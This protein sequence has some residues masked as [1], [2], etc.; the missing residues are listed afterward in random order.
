[1]L[2]YYNP[3]TQEWS[4]FP[5]PGFVIADPDYLFGNQSSKP[6]SL[7]S[8]SKSAIL[9]QVGAGSP[10]VPPVALG[11]AP[12]LSSN[13][14]PGA[15][16][17]A[18]EVPGLSAASNR[19]YDMTSA[20]ADQD[21]MG[22]ILA[23]LRNENPEFFKAG[24]VGIER[25]Q[26]D[27]ELALKKEAYDKQSQQ[28]ERGYALD[29]KKFNAEQ[30][31][32]TDRVEEEKKQAALEHAAKLQLSGMEPTLAT[33]VSNNIF[34]NKPMTKDQAAAYKNL[35]IQSRR[36]QLQKPIP[37][38]IPNTEVLRDPKD[39]EAQ[40]QMEYPGYQSPLLGMSGEKNPLN[41]ESATA[42]QAVESEKLAPGTGQLIQK[43]GEEVAAQ[44][45]SDKVVSE[46]IDRYKN[47]FAA[48]EGTGLSMTSMAEQV[49][50]AIGYLEQHGEYTPE[51]KRRIKDWLTTWDFTRYS[52]FPQSYPS[53]P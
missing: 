53:A 1:M 27:K 44:Q 31:R 49:Q 23:G 48:L 9:G 33:A 36:E 34:L 40:L 50:T 43:R 10:Y 20:M 39:I 2:L 3:D 47:H 45:A 18:F 15:T 30:K 46:A 12:S 32:F 52:I 7:G 38:S 11:Q 22:L 17:P 24:Q 4:N 6:G 37:G 16:F 25:Q 41:P 29:E 42:R 26:S 28:L 35:L 14:Q 5:K 8:A 21:P 13:P 51:E 19:A